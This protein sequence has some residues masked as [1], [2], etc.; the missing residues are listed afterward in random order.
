[1]S[2]QPEHRPNAAR[3]FLRAVTTPGMHGSVVAIDPNGN[4]KLLAR[5]YTLDT[6][7]DVDKFI[8]ANSHRNLYWT[9]NPLKSAINTKPKKSDVAAMACVHLDL[10]DPS[11]EALARLRAYHLSPTLIVFSGGGYQAFWM[12]REPIAVDDENIDAL[13]AANKRVAHDLGGDPAPGTWTASCDCRELQTGRRP[14]KL[15]KGAPVPCWPS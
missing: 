3:E 13:E 2:A 7:D 10:D 12:L 5:A 9:P 4:D 6:L 8:A 14:P 15:R 1:M 11:P